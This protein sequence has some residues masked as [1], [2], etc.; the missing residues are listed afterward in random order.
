MFFFALPAFLDGA[1]LAVGRGGAASLEIK[2]K[3]QRA[4]NVGAEGTNISWQRVL[5]AALSLPRYPGYYVHARAR[6]HY[7]LRAHAFRRVCCQRKPMAA[8]RDHPRGTWCSGIT[9]ASHA[10]GPGF[11]SQ[12]VH[13]SCPFVG[14]LTFLTH[15]FS[16]ARCAPLA[17]RAP[18]VAP[19]FDQVAPGAV[20]A[21]LAPGC[22]S[23]PP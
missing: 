16:G 15:A 3:E 1:L 21:Q 17:S 11:K 9:S 7:S 20:R 14:T 5:G 10:E 4:H 18:A 6:A 19:I 23:K 13:F 22:A 2:G 8:T 12:C